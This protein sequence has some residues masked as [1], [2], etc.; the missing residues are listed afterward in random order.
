[1]RTR[2][3]A[4]PLFT[5]ICVLVGVLVIVQLW[6]LSSSLEAV[7]AGDA[8]PAVAATLASLALFALSA[9]LLRYGLALDRNVR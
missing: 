2:K 3:Q 9:G 4:T 5:T 6:L 7:L 1:M 8:R